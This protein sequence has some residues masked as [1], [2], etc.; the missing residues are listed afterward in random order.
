MKEVEQEKKDVVCVITNN[1]YK[2]VYISAENRFHLHCSPSEQVC[3]PQIQ[4]EKSQLYS[5]YLGGWVRSANSF[6]LYANL[7]PIFTGC[8]VFFCCTQPLTIHLRAA[9]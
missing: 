7:N 8:R 6:L 3:D 4:G 5:H 9:T 1:T 2:A